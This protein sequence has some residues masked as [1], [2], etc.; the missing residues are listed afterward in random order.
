MEQVKSSP[1]QEALEAVESLPM[2]DQEALMELVERRLAEWRRAEIA[3]N[4]KATL[5]A[6]REGRAQFGS[7]DDLKRD[8]LAGQ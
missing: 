3:R 4:A 1:L 5:Q 8:L 7:V 2:E 6:V